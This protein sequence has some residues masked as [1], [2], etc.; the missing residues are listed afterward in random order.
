MTEIILAIKHPHNGSEEIA[1][2]IQELLMHHM[3]NPLHYTEE[4]AAFLE[5]NQFNIFS[6]VQKSFAQ[7]L[8][9]PKTDLCNWI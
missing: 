7:E 3:N 9:K 2:W 8:I 4:L 1:K 6:L 5:P